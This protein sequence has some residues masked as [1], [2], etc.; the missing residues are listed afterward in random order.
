[1]VCTRG[2]TINHRVHDRTAP[3]SLNQQL[4]PGLV[5]AL[6]HPYL[7]W[8]FIIEPSEYVFCRASLTFLD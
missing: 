8:Q 2:C 1:V 3:V 4:S 5:C 7:L 6:S